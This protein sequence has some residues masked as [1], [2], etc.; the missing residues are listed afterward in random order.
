MRFHFFFVRSSKRSNPKQVKSCFQGCLGIGCCVNV[1]D[2]CSRGVKYEIS[3]SIY[4]LFFTFSPFCEVEPKYFFHVFFVYFLFI[5][6]MSV[7]IHFPFQISE[8]PTKS[9]EEKTQ[10]LSGDLCMFVPFFL[11]LFLGARFPSVLSYLF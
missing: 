2:L 3:S 1:F 6:F 11:G 4:N 10:L 7:F 8:T 5:F 9:Q